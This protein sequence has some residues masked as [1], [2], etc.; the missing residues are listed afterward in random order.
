MAI[1]PPPLNPERERL[2]ALVAFSLR[3]VERMAHKVAAAQHDH[4][5]AVQQLTRDH[6]ALDAWIAANPPAQPDLFQE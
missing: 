1:E 4:G 3:R 6:A 5:L 2:E